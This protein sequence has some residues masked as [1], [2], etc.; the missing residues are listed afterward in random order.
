MCL[1]YFSCENTITDSPDILDCNNVPNGSASL[2]D[3]GDCVAPEDFN[4]AQD[5]TGVCD[6]SSSFDN[7][8]VCYPSGQD[9]SFNEL[10]ASKITLGN[11]DLQGILNTFT[12]FSSRNSCILLQG[13][14]LHLITNPTRD[15]SY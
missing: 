6:G 11:S 10:E 1:F 3:C 13:Q 12:P 7:C 4:G 8:G 5:C 15:K 2:D 9:A 14:V